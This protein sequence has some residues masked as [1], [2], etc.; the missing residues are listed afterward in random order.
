M[1]EYLR[2]RGEMAAVRRRQFLPA[3]TPRQKGPGLQ[4]LPRPKSEFCAPPRTN[5]FH[6]MIRRTTGPLVEVIGGGEAATGVGGAGGGGTGTGDGASA[7]YRNR[8]R[9]LRRQELHA[10]RWHNSCLSGSGHQAARP[11]SRQ[12]IAFEAICVPQPAQNLLPGCSTAMHSA[13]SQK[14]RSAGLDC[15]QPRQVR[16]ATAGAGTG[17]AALRE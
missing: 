17:G 4:G 11:H 5:R 14:M 3:I 2:T 6:A 16:A 15:P 9:T 13:F 12:Y 8:S 1:V 7:P 10:D